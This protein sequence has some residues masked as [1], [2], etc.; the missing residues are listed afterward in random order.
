VSQEDLWRNVW[1]LIFFMFN[2][3]CSL[4]TSFM[5][6]T[7]V[8][9]PTRSLWMFSIIPVLIVITWIQHVVMEIKKTFGID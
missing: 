5:Q 7:P 6:R 8:V 2:I 4:Y 9:L 1:I 3:T